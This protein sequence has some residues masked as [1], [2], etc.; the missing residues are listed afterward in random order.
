MTGRADA[1]FGS[2]PNVLGAQE[3]PGQ[4]NMAEGCQREGAKNVRR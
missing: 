2:S 3:G 4:Q 1:E